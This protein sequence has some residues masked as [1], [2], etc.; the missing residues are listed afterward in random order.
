MGWDAS[1]LL[2]IFKRQRN[3]RPSVTIEIEGRV[4]TY[5]TEKFSGVDVESCILKARRKFPG[6]QIEAIDDQTVAGA[7]ESC[8]KPLFDGDDYLYD[9]EGIIWCSE[10][11]SED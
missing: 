5:V 3:V 7:C 1:R 2:P 11:D 4:V 6:I 10:C 8:G 9:D